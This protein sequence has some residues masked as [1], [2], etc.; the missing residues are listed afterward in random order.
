METIQIILIMF[1]LIKIVVEL[2]EKAKK[3]K[4]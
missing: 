3:D 2:I 1:Q 4:Q